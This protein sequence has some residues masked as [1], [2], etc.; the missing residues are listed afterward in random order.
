MF[1]RYWPGEMI[2]QKAGWTSGVGLGIN[3][4][5]SRELNSDIEACVA[6][7][8][9]DNCKGFLGWIQ[10]N[11]VLGK[12]FRIYIE[13]LREHYKFLPTNFKKCLLSRLYAF[14]LQM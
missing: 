6:S 14:F 12:K 9:T 13:I 3:L 5:L 10:R 2:V 11:C 1:I 4:L 7:D 8:V